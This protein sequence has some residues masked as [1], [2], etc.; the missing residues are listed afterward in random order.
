MKRGI[1]ITSCFLVIIALIVGVFSLFVGAFVNDNIDYNL[2]ERLFEAA[3]ES[4]TAAFF[5]YD[6]NGDL[7]EVWKSSL[8]E[9]K[10]WSPLS[11]I[12]RYVI[13]GFIS[14]EDRTFYEHNGVN[15]KRTAYAFFNM[16]FH[17]K[18][19]F[20][21]S[22]ITQQVVKNMSGDNET[23]VRRKIGEMLRAFNLEN[24]H[25]K[26]EILEVYLNIVPMSGNIYGVNEAA[27]TYFSK[28]PEELSLS[29]AAT[30]VG[31]T[32][33]PARFNPYNHPEECIEK[34][35]RVLYAMLDN[36]KIS[37][38]EYEKAKIEPLIVAENKNKDEKVCSW[39]VETA[40][41][42]IV[43]D[44]MKEYNLSE[45]A[46]RLLLNS[47]TKT[48]LTV[49]IKVQEI[50]EEVFENLNE[51]SSA[52]SSGLDY[53]M[54][55]VDNESGNLVGIIGA[56]GEK[57]GN[58]LLN[59]ATVPR[60]PGST[61]KPLSLYA[62]L[63]ESNIINWSTVIDDTPISVEEKDGVIISYPKNSPDIYEGKITVKDAL[64]LS[65]NTIAVRLYNM[66]G[67]ERI[68]NSLKENF[69]FNLIESLNDNG[70]VITDMEM[71]PLALGQLSRGIPLR[72]LTEAYTVFP[73][74]GV[75]R[76]AKSY[77]GVFDYEGKILLENPSVEKRIY[78]SDTANLVT[79][80]LS[81]VV[82][83]GTARSVKL[84]NIVDTA[85]KT[86]T[87]GND[88]DR[89]FIG[90]TPYYTAGI[91]TGYRNSDKS[92]GTQSPNHIELWDKIMTKLH[93]VTLED[94][95]SDDYKGFSTEGL[96]RIEYC[97]DTGKAASEEC[98]N[99]E[100]GY[101]KKQTVLEDCTPEM[102]KLPYYDFND[103][104]DVFVDNKRK[105]S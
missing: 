71:A 47:G 50:L 40:I 24:N 44:L 37:N 95:N 61:I 7:T 87:S 14:M 88:K 56:C 12:S 49:N 8:G 43:S 86:G 94:S 57:K 58:R 4:K 66:L 15:I 55:V 9:K 103:D 2:D 38:E 76:N 77:L 25:T 51:L 1:I 75:L 27:N 10:T 64:R 104:V 54:V 62:P 6:K 98:T 48:I 82:E 102:E 22:T 32:N 29:E 81:T 96:I 26:E 69:G 36:K 90:F 72:S 89:L 68:F 73:N 65:K 17:F 91:W 42:D 79:Q 41:S 23:T 70:R 34:R 85:G 19:S 84:K 67:K 101:Y 16:L 83:N 35:N 59:L 80:L 92:V 93:E 45:N 33:S 105:A 63:I 3:K 11:S 97:L 46:A 18:D 100:Y 31:I 39:F 60:T 28:E 78:D 30:I 5:A 21:A 20:G 52:V 53:S 74:R 99:T 13:D